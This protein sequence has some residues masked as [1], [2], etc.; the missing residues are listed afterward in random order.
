MNVLNAILGGSRPKPRLT[1]LALAVLVLSAGCR[2]TRTR[3]IMTVT[4]TVPAADMGITLTHEH[5][6]VDFTGADRVGEA[7]YDP[8]SAASVILPHLL[9]LRD[10]GCTTF[11]ECTPEHLGRDPALLRRLSMASGL[12]FLTNTGYYGA[13]ENR[14]LPLSYYTEDANRIAKRWI[15]EWLYGIE[16]T[17]VRPGFIKIGFPEGHLSDTHRK[18]IR[19][20]ARTHLRTGLVIASHTGPA[21]GAFDQIEILREEGVDPSAWIWVH[22]QAE[23]SPDAL[24]TG[25]RLGAWISFDN[26]GWVSPDTLIPRLKTLRDRGCLGRVLL[27][28]DAGWYSVGQPGG[29]K[30]RGHDAIFTGFLPAL[31]KAGFTM[32]EIRAMM[33]DNPATAFEIRVRRPGHLSHRMK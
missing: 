9:R 18:L 31:E 2:S 7:G 3:N 25:A 22:A 20:A 29:G 27:S 30:Y 24:V 5:V 8:D 28:Q 11:V 1:A 6:L 12:R 26:I 13:M 19:A 14:F 4:G 15:A 21:A 17:G 23:G 32:D 10:L 33:T 16:G